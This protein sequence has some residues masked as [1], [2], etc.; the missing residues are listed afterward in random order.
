M[1]R[2]KV[3]SFQK[4]NSSTWY[5][6]CMLERKTWT[7]SRELSHDTVLITCI[8]SRDGA[9]T[10]R[11]CQQ[12]GKSDARSVTNQRTFPGKRLD[13]LKF[14]SR[15]QKWFMM[16]CGWSVPIYP[17]LPKGNGTTLLVWAPF[18]CWRGAKCMHKP[19]SSS[20]KEGDCGGNLTFLLG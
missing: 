17:P 11:T 5:Q 18:E 19:Y 6:S 4:R 1:T 20:Q 14:S 10:T 3:E 15:I 8:E 12:T 7:S 9:Y 2:K 16:L 13:K